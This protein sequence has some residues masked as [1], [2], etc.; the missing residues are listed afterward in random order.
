MLGAVTAPTE[1]TT[2]QTPAGAKLRHQ[3]DKDGFFV[4]PGLLTAGE[5]ADFKSKMQQHSGLTDADFDEAKARRGG[6][7][8]PDGVTRTEDFWPL[9]FNERL[10][11]AIRDSVGPDAR[12]TQHSDL[13]VHHG[14]VGWHRDSANREFG[15]GPDW[16]ESREPYR[17]A[18]V[19][20]YL[21]PYGASGS[22]L[23]VLPGTQHRESRVL[24]TEL[25]LH[26]RLRAKRPDRLPPVL[27]AR[28]RWIPTE[29]GDCVIFNQR[30][31]HSGSHIHGPKY[32]IFLSYGADNHHSR[33]HRRYYIEKRSE[34]GYGDY[35]QALAERLR[36]QDLYLPLDES[37]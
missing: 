32:A 36:Q 15:V 1:A 6:W 22:K 35:P 23:G 12:Y 17:I 21:Q 7:F 24:R 4:I 9:I 2:A 25:G 10:V 29:P 34:L 37:A 13:H 31:L 14:T 30:I 11:S 8:M 28:T 5:V 18:R 19:A 20:I 3:F 16:D 33:N 26:E 27:S